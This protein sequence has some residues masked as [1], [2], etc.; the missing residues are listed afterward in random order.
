[1]GYEGYIVSSESKEDALHFRSSTCT[2]WQRIEPQI[3]ERDD[4]EGKDKAH[5]LGIVPRALN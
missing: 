2:D 1:M 5:W 4:N 3:D